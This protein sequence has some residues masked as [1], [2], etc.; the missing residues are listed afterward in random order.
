M[1][2]VIEFGGTTFTDDTDWRG[3]VRHPYGFLRGPFE[4]DLDAAS[5]LGALAEAL[6]GTSM[7]SQLADAALEVIEQGSEPTMDSMV[8]AGWENAPNALERMLALVAATP[9]TVSDVWLSRIYGALLRRAPTD[10]RVLDHLERDARDQNGR[11]FLEAAARYNPGWLAET[12]ASLRPSPT[13]DFA[14]WLFVTGAPEAGTNAT[15]NVD[16]ESARRRL[17]DAIANL[18][19]PYQAA[20]IAQLNEI[21]HR[22]PGSSKHRALQRALQEHPVFSAALREER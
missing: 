19:E 6:R 5:A 8:A 12:L 15:T 1:R 11:R 3:L 2:Q 9:R 17:L 22:S 16:R 4:R 7:E 13:A 18:G 10:P 21:A 14:S 20:L